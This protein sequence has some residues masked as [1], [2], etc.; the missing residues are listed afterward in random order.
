ML[1]RQ[2]IAIFLQGLAY[3]LLQTWHIQACGDRKMVGAVT[4]LV[5]LYAL[6]FMWHHCFVEHK[7]FRS[8]AWITLSTAL[9]A[10]LGTALWLCLGG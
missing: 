10:C 3:D 6:G 2:C 5:G 1:W 9:G 4:T 8:R 7:D